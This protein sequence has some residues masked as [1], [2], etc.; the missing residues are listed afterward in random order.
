MHDEK[1]AQG[2]PEKSAPGTEKLKS[3]HGSFNTSTT[4]VAI[5][6]SPNDDDMEEEG[7][8]DDVLQLARRLTTQSN[9]AG[10]RDLFPVVQD[11]PLDP[12]SSHFNAKKWAKAF[13]KAKLDSLEGSLPRTT[14]VAFKNLNVYGF[15]S[16]TDFQKSVGN[17]LLEIGT[18]AKR[19]IN[20]TDQRID[21]LHDLEG[22]VHSGEMLCVLG[23]PGSGCTT[24]LRT[25]SGE[26]HGFHIE[27]SSSI[28]YQGI[29]PKQM[30]TNFRGEAIYTA[31]VDH[32]FPQLTVGDTLYFAACAR[33]PRN[34][35]TAT[36]K[37][38]AEHLRDVTMA[39]FAVV[40]GRESRSPRPL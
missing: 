2:D 11:G 30:R 23:P 19:L 13:Y 7:I 36:R 6:G 17:V 1:S 37:E 26:T 4:D 29:H 16:D 39:M 8:H 27:K 18:L 15:G 24:F 28:N 32:H 10:P 31:E 34:V 22:V 35:P 3:T 38:Y 14:G 9:G 12:N 33:C 40:R 21:I 20:R 5:N 25:I